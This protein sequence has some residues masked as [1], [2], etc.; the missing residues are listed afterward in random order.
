MPPQIEFNTQLFY[1]GALWLAIIDFIL[2]ALLV[3]FLDR[4]IYAKLFFPIAIFTCVFWSTLWT[5]VFNFTWDWY[6]CLVFPDWVRTSAPL[7]GLIYTPVGLL[8]WLIA[9]HIPA[10][11]I[12]MFSL[13]GGAEGLIVHAWAIWRL[14]LIE[15]IPLMHGVDPVSVLAFAFTEK[16]LY[17]SII[18]AG[19]YLIRLV[20]QRIS[21][22]IQNRAA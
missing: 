4:S 9:K 1:Q 3:R 15:N 10:N 20:W 13:L 2:V 8:I 21:N 18:I 22:S 16:V 14:K 12:L 7:L 17:W 5:L 11:P 6:Y 19:A